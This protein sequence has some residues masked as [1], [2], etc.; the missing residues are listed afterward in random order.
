[1]PTQI[2]EL[3]QSRGGLIVAGF[4]FAAVIAFFVYSLSSAF[5]TSAAG[6]RTRDRTFICAATGKVFQHRIEAGDTIPVESPYSGEATGYEA[7]RCYWTA[8]GHV[9][10]E[11]T[12]V[13]LNE[14]A[15]K[16]G[17][18]FCPDCGRVVVRY[19]PRPIGPDDRPPPTRD[20]LAAR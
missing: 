3:L 5:G 2:R 17:R 9:K 15:D 4:A 12:M 20:Q 14:Y 16:P 11:P 1:M 7:E 13:L 10:D 6:D 18:T 8:D 19:N